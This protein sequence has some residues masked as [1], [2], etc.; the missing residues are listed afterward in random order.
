MCICT[1]HRPE[2]LRRLLQSL[3]HI[4]HAG[5]AADQ[6]AVFVVDNDPQSEN[7][8]ICEQAAQ[9]LE[10]KLLY[11]PEPEPGVTYARNTA[12]ASALD[13]GADFVSF[14]DDDDIPRSGWLAELLQQQAQT[15]ADLIFG[16]WR[17]AED[18][19]E[20]ASRAGIFRDP[21]RNK[22]LGGGSGR[23][24]L[25][26]CA[27]TCNV[28]VSRNILEQLSAIGPVFDH[29]FKFS[30]G[31]DKD[32]FIRARELGAILTSADKSIINLSYEAE[33]YRAR[34]LLQR[35]FKCGCSQAGMAR[36]HGSR[37]R[38]AKMLAKAVIK[39]PLVLLTLPF[40]CVHTPWLLNHLYRLG[41]SYGVLYA[42]LTRRSFNYYAKGAHS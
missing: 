40:T 22:A 36:V 37:Q 31:E 14:I 21:T 29:R 2:P 38:V 18:T 3:R 11:V 7:A 28:M 5:L 30:G 41:K 39:I 9:S 19:P 27:S 33:R 17:T 23:Y 35:G 20:W 10:F 26:V 6:I 25:P 32:F 34:G 1:Y 8:E 12:V 42:S 4:E 15:G 24:G 16:S 13:W